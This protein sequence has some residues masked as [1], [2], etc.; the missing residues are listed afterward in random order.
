MKTIKQTVN[1]KASPHDVYEAL[2]D[3]KKHSRFTGSSARISSK[4]GGRFSAYGGGIKGK[5]LQLVKDKKIVQEWYCETDGWPEG[6]FSKATFLLSK[7]KTGT[8]MTFI[9][10]NVPDGAYKS[11]KQGW[12]DYYWKPMKEMLEK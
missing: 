3:S 1:F 2:M 12:T 6:H 7:T 5:N 11:I 10:T 9:Q 4:V 8:K